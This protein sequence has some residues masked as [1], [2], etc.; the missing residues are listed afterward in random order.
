MLGF[1]IFGL[2]VIVII[3][4]V[5]LGL[6]GDRWFG[7]GRPSYRWGGCDYDVEDDL[8]EAEDFADFEIKAA[9][10]D[11][12]YFTDDPARNYDSYYAQVADDAMMGDEM[13]MEIM[14]DEFGD[15]E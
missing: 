9:M 7:H 3:S 1:I 6:N 12:D 4:T 11:R 2:P 5:I 13:A 14:R 10:G 8:Y 15:S